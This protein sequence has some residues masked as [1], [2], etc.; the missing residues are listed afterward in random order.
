MSPHP[1]AA[2]SASPPRRFSLA[3]AQRVYHLAGRG[4]RLGD[5]VKEALAVIH[6]AVGDYGAEHVALSFNGGKD[7]TVLVH[8][9]AASLLFHLLPSSFPFSSFFS[10]KSRTTTTASSSLPLS[11]PRHPSLTRTAS[12]TT[13]AS[14][15]TSRSSSP[16]PSSAAVAPSLI[17]TSSAL[18]PIPTVYI[19]CASPFPQ[20]EAFVSLCVDWYGLELE[21]VEAGMKEALGSYLERNEAVKAVLVGV[22]R[23]DPHG[24]NLQHLQPTDPSWPTFMRVHPIL[25]WSYGDV[26]AFLREGSLT[27]GAEEERKEG[28]EGEGEKKAEG[29]AEGKGLGLEWCELYDYGYT[30][31]GSTHNTFP[32][33]LLRATTTDGHYSGAE[34]EGSERAP[35][36][37]WRPAWELEDEAAERAGRETNVASVVAQTPH[38]PGQ[39][40]Q[41]QLAGNGVKEDQGK[42]EDGDVPADAEEPIGEAG[43]GTKEGH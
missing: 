20:V 36:G 18:P 32:N 34:Q 40:D 2:S 1:P 28:E 7:C 42:K 29:K 4:D 33:P 8:L 21:A 31:L 10:R 6:E 24:A 14:T 15:S 12:T 35:L 27:L 26:W 5:K 38:Q 16:Y 37:G 11:K 41:P 22:R 39:P 30:S 3:D 17:S 23:G 19:R 13:S 9:L 43:D 25:D